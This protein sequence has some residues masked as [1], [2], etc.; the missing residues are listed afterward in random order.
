MI[1]TPTV[2]LKWVDYKES[3]DPKNAVPFT[4]NVGWGWPD[5]VVLQQKWVNDEGG[6]EWRDVEL[7]INNN[8]KIKSDDDWT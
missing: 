7:E 4:H 8:L 1:W 5:A 6:I 2:E 3:V